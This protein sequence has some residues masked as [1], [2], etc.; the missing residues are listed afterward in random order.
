[1]EIEYGCNISNRYH[2][3]LQF[4]ENAGN[5]AYETDKNSN[6]ARR[7]RKSKRRQKMLEVVDHTNEIVPAEMDIVESQQSIQFID[8]DVN[9]APNTETVIKSENKENDTKISNETEEEEEQEEQEQEVRHSEANWNEL[10]LM[11]E[12]ATA[13]EKEKQE[14]VDNTPKRI[15]STVIYYN[16]NFG[17]GNRVKLFGDDNGSRANGRHHKTFGTNRNRNRDHSQEVKQTK[18]NEDN[19]NSF[20]SDESAKNGKEEARAVNTDGE[21][22]AGKDSSDAKKRKPRTTRQNDNNA[23]WNHKGPRVFSRRKLSNQAV[24]HFDVNTK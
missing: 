18:G 6:K 7:K 19:H 5:D 15:Y 1:M 2:D 11:E 12:Q 13:Q 21:G 14:S 23:I 24:D 10:C 3:F 9:A 4:N 16:R 17:N 22:N 20:A 8:V